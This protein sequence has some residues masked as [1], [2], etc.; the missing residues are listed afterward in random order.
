MRGSTHFFIHVERAVHHGGQMILPYDNCSCSEVEIKALCW[1]FSRLDSVISLVIF[2]LRLKPTHISQLS[3]QKE[4]QWYWLIKSVVLR[5]QSCVQNG[6]EVRVS[7]LDTIL[8]HKHYSNK[9]PTGRNRGHGK[10]KYHSLVFGKRQ[11]DS[12]LAW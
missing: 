9:I 1:G 11:C 12:C 7:I 8:Y 4:V 5:V 3:W 6:A 10:W 2:M